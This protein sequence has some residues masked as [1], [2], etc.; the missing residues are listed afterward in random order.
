M[1]T[2]IEEI[3]LTI[4]DVAH[5]LNIAPSHAR[6]LVRLGRLRGKDMSVTGKR[7]HWRIHPSWLRDFQD[8]VPEPPARTQDCVPKSPRPV[9]GMDID[10]A[11]PLQP[12]CAHCGHP[13]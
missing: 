11:D 7:Q 8:C 13:L 4:G 9:T 12:H 2:A 10:T 6:K 5:I 3:W 1:P